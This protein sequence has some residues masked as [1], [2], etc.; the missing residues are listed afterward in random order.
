MFTKLGVIQGATKYNK[1]KQ[2]QVKNVV[3]HI[4]TPT[5]QNWKQFLYDCSLTTRTTNLHIDPKEDVI[6]AM[7][8]LNDITLDDGPF[9]Y[10][11]KKSNR[12]IYDDLQNIFGRTISTGSYCDTPQS[13]TSCISIP[14]ICRVSH[15]FGRILLDDEEQKMIVEKEKC[16]QV[17]KVIYVSLIPIRNIEEVFVIRG[18]RIVYKY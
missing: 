4:A 6:K 11:E 14:K 16:L 8:Y 3:L 13:S 2:L 15:N 18:T 5:D 7:M 10:V 17:I 1:G 12:W 9:S